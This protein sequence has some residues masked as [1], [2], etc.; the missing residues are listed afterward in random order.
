MNKAAVISSLINEDNFL[1]NIKASD[2]MFQADEPLA[3]GGTDLA[4]DPLSMALGALGACTAMTL[5]IYYAHK[6]IDWQNIEVHVSSELISINKDT[7]PELHIAMA[8]NGKIRKVLKTIY[9]KSDISDKLL[10]RTAIIAEKC[11]VNLM[12]KNSCLMDLQIKRVL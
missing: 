8:N 6:G 1:T 11:P 10:E 5:K 9:I 12:M 3:A 4:T 7:A 2:H